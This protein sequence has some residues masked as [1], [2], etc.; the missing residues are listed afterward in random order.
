MRGL[1]KKKKVDSL[2]F[3]IQN[4]IKNG[5]EMIACQMSMDIM[6]VKKEELLDGVKIGGVATYLQETE[7]SNLNLFI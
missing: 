3:M 1:M 6:G 4:G 7:T 2:E 5:I